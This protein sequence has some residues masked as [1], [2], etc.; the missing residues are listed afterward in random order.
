MFNVL[1]TELKGIVT[2][3]LFTLNFDPEYLREGIN[4][5]DGS[6][7]E[8]ASDIIDKLKNIIRL[9]SFKSLSKNPINHIL[10]FD[11]SSTKYRSF[12]SEMTV[13]GGDTHL[14]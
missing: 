14:G 8:S 10:D 6:L 1:S 13:E 4:V 11:V 12:I 7:S 5:P 9:S 2:E 3:S